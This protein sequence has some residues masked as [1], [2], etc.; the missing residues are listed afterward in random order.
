MCAKRNLGFEFA[1]QQFGDNRHPA[2]AANQDHRGEVARL[3]ARGAKDARGHRDAVPKHGPNKRH[4]LWPAQANRR[5]VP[6][7]RHGDLRV[8]FGRERLL[9]LG[10]GVF[11]LGQ[12]TPGIRVVLLELS[13]ATAEIV[14]DE[15]KY[16][17]IEIG[18]RRMI[19][20]F[21]LA[22]D[23][24][25]GRY[26]FDHGDFTRPATKVVNEDSLTIAH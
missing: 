7:Q 11:D 26:L 21:A 12:Q 22:Q 19:G 9:R 8:R 3:N 14:E 4:E 25:A 23:A 24:H 15:S 17:L 5:V 20:S 18:A 6:R 16:G 1:L 13:A 2:A 10:A